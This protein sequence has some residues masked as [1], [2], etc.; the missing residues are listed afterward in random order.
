VIA[1][2]ILSAA[3]LATATLILSPIAT[4]ADYVFR[5]GEGW[6]REGGIFGSSA[7]V[8]KTSQLQLSLAEDFEKKGDTASARE[9]YTQL[10]KNFS[11]SNQAP[12][13]KFRLAQLLDK[14]G[15]YESAFEAYDGYISKHP[16]GK[17]FSTALEG[18]FNIAKRFMEG[19]RRRLFGIKMF[20]SNQR[21]EEMFDTILK[22]APYSNIAAQVLL[23]RGM[24]MERQGKDAEAIV[25]Y[26]QI[27]DRFP[28][29]KIAEEAQYQMGYVRMR[30]VRHGSYD[31]VDRIR[32]QES[33]EDF[34][35]RSP[36][37][38][39]SAQAREN[40][41]TLESKHLNS[42]LDA[43]KFYDKS[44]KTK[45]AAIYYKDVIAESPESPEGKY[46]QKRL[47]I[48]KGQLG[49]DSIRTGN[50]APEN[51][52]NAASKRRMQAAI[53]TVSRPDYVGPQIKPAPVSRPDSGPALRLSPSDLSPLPEPPLP[54]T[55][56]ILNPEKGT[57]SPKQ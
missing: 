35:L 42:I 10:I 11:L 46:A 31:K 18:M 32:A 9:A 12:V 29:E 7:P 25:T 23:F 15:Q 5:P 57:T 27:M 37:S 24:V 50:E 16:D 2:P 41:K 36:S 39:K 56:P 43:A 21:A 22:R 45:A 51:A 40:L 38:E 30:S 44:G 19:E 33:F 53:N 20:S 28:G 55:D 47:E 3:V 8:A 14:Q 1:R 49:A 54:L 6:K 17:D 52:E 13:A 48:L 4:R 34:I 26:Q